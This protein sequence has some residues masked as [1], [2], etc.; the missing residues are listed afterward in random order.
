MM[1][2]L[3]L[4]IKT[5]QRARLVDVPSARLRKKLQQKLRSQ[6]TRILIVRAAALSAR[7]PRKQKLRRLVAARRTKKNPPAPAQR[8][9]KIVVAVVKKMVTRLRQ[10]RN[11]AISKSLI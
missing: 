10:L 7:Q 9:K 5:N 1:L 11:R 3:K 4:L 6:R 2:P 8:P